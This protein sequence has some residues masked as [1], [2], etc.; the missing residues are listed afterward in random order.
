MENIE[1]I[2][3]QTIQRYSDRY[4]KL[5]YDAKTLGWGSAEQQEYRFL[6]TLDHNITFKGKSLLDIG[7]GFGDYF[8]FLK[9]QNSGIVKYTGYDI[10]SDLI[11]EANQKNQD[12]IAS[13]EMQNILDQTEENIADIV[14]MLGVLN[15]NLK[16]KMDNLEYSKKF[17]HKAFQLAKEV[18]IVDFLST[19]LTPDY[20]KEEFVY[21][22]SPY[23]ILEYAFLLSNN[24]VLKHNYLAIPQKE[25]MIFIYKDQS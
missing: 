13:F 19:K 17:I 5:G 9:E 23:K 18:V 6:Q 14:V 15:F 11:N 4:K 12:D 2:T 21:Y 16:G 10:N 3:S 25:F 7:C 1:Q 24:V 8:H 22:H 20:P